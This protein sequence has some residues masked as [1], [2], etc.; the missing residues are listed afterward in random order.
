LKFESAKQVSV[1]YRLFWKFAQLLRF[2][3]LVITFNK[4]FGKN[5]FQGR[6]QIMFEVNGLSAE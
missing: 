6:Y 5:D 3:V 2:Q 4:T 1:K